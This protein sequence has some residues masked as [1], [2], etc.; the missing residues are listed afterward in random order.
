MLA[1]RYSKV[2]IDAFVMR[3]RARLFIGRRL[4]LGHRELWI[5]RRVILPAGNRKI[6]DTLL[7]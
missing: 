3:Q 4:L 6:A 1:P 7:R 2:M 5:T